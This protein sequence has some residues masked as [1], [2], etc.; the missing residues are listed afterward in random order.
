MRHRAKRAVVLAAAFALAAGCGETELP[1]AH[2]VEPIVSASAKGWSLKAGPPQGRSGAFSTTVVVNPKGEEFNIGVTQYP[3][4][5][6]ATLWI[7]RVE[8]LKARFLLIRVPPAASAAVEMP[9]VYLDEDDRPSLAGTI[10]QRFEFPVHPQD[11]AGEDPKVIAV[12]GERRLRDLLFEDSDQ[13]G[14]PE[15][16]ENDVWKEG[17][18]VTYFRFTSAKKF[19]PLYRE[20]WARPDDKYDEHVRVSREKC[21]Q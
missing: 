5:L 2:N 19:V 9:V 6:P 16:V 21:P 12:D 15:L 3:D 1:P 18:T 8:E 10:R 13:D 11:E 14:V 17:G 20:V 7:V 4:V